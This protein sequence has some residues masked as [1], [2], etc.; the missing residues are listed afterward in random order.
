MTNFEMLTCSDAR[1]DRK[2]A[3]ETKKKLIKKLLS[4]SS[5]Q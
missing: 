2:F 5:R 1:K 4:L 3:L